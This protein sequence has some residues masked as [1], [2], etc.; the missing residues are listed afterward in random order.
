MGALPPACGG[1]SG[2]GPWTP[3]S[4]STQVSLVHRHVLPDHSVSKHLG[5]P[6][7][8]LSRYPSAPLASSFWGPDFA[9]PTQAR[10]CHPAESSLLSYGLVVHLLLLS[11]T[12][13]C[14]AVAFG[15]RPESVCLEKTLTSLNVRAPRRAWGGALPR[16]RYWN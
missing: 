13:R 11:T 14:V 6:A 7:A 4:V 9:I 16:R 8:A 5:T 10:R 2:L 12:H 3:L 15:Y 1:S